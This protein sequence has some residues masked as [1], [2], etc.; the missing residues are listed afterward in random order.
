MSLHGLSL[1]ADTLAQ[2]GPKTFRPASPLTSELLEPI[3]H[4]AT[5]DDA[6]RALIQADES[7]ALFRRTSADVRAALLEKIAE[8][9][10]AI[11]DELLTRAH[12]E[13]GL[14]LDRLTGERG[15]TV[16]Q[17]RLFAGVVREGSWCDARIDT[18]LPDRKPVPKPDLRRMLIPLGPVIVFGASNFPLAFSVAGG[19]TASA[20]ATGCPVIVKAHPAH[21][22]TSELVGLAI[23]RALADCGLPAGI[24]SMLH[25]GAETGLALVRHPLAR[26]VGFTG[27]RAAGLAL[28]RAANERPEPIPVFAEMSSLNPVFILPGALRERSAQI[29]DGLKTS[30]TMGIGQFCTKPGLVFGLGGGAFEN[31]AEQFAGI[32]GAAAPGTMLHGGICD[33]YHRSLDRAEKTPGVIALAMSDIEP[34][35]AKTQGEPVVFATDAEDFFQH[36]ELHE[37]V[38]GPYT[39]LVTAG[40]WEELL[41]AA[42]G[43]EGQLTATLFATPDDLANAS[44][45][46]AILERKAGR[47]LLNSFPTGVEVCPA[48][49]HGGPFPA[50]TDS[51]FTSV[52][53]AAIQRF[54]RPVCYQNFLPDALAPELR[55][56]NPRGL[57]RIVNGDFTRESIPETK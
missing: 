1:I 10:L 28:W 31:F 30:V 12:A 46:L 33:A 55:D 18:A 49:Q 17:L 22:G 34:D 50:T 26:A 23:Q 27:S 45:L 41:T 16:G 53:T 39:L 54:A 24:F 21:P 2:P 13:S 32:I 47:L 4:E 3:F 8:E 35:P 37:E 43:L 9:I 42:H 36:R 6:D 56:E 7:F 57:L 51:R 40:T 14:P 19:D 25:G 11:G 5:A 15:R 52:G 29:A 44:D 38:F 20:L 48:M